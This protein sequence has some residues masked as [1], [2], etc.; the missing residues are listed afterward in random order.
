[1]TPREAYMNIVRGNT[2][3]VP[4]SEVTGRIAANALL[5]YPPGIPLLMSGENFGNANSP[6]IAY[7]KAL[8]QWNQA[9]PGFDHIT[10]GLTVSNGKGFVMCVK[11]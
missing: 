8:Q 7:L 5:P 4:V 2:E 11:K 9:F 1:M 3:L 6:V 10:E